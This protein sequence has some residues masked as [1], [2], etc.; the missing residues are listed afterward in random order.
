MPLRHNEDNL[1]MALSDVCPLALD[2]RLMDTA[3]GKT[4]LLFQMH[5]FRIAP[6]IR[7]Y[8]TD[9]KIVVDASIRIINALIDL[10][11]H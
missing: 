5:F 10:C 6:P 2:N 9:K 4:F 8:L 11:A 1:N 3:Q 7:D